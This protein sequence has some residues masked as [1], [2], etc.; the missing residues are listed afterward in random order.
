M[1]LFTF[2][3]AIMMIAIALL[4]DMQ[5]IV[6]LVLVLLVFTARSLTMVLLLIGVVVVLFII[7]GNEMNT[8]W[9]L[10]LLALVVIGLMIGLKT[11]PEQPEYF[12]PE[13]GGMGGMG[14]GGF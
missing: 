13:M 14:E 9:P 8:L 10:V 3:V 7:Q 1:D 12:A 2:L 11:Q 5:W 6:L 4:Y